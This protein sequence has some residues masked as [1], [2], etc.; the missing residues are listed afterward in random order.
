M[1]TVIIARQHGEDAARHAREAAVQR[2]CSGLPG[3]QVLVTP[4]LY[5]LPADSPRWAELAVLPGDITI[6]GWLHPR[7][8]EW[9]LRA[10][11][12]GQ[13]VLQAI[14]LA[15]EAAVDAWLASLPE[16]TDEDAAR[17]LSEE[18]YERWYPVVDYTRCEG[19]RHCLQ[20]CLFGVYALDNEKVVVNNP[21]ACKHGCPACS[22]IC[23]QGAIIFPLYTKD[24]AIAG[25]PGCY[26]TPDLA[27]RKLYYQRT[28]LPCPVCGSAETGPGAFAPDDDGCAECGRH[29]T[30]APADEA[31]AAIDAL[32]DDL[33]ALARKRQP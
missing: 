9:L 4:S 20:F 26:P 11:G 10:H 25:A 6:L 3:W 32:I 29:L 23:P 12:V 8:L 15:D 5:H 27:A 14:D 16:S 24:P 31:L 7:P 21:D 2:R 28:K 17:T 30:D 1:Q 19:C 13:N 18:T 33:D 22:R